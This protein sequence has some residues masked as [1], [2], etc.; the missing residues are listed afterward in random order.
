MG[1]NLGIALGAGVQTG[2]NTYTKMQEEGIAALTKARE[3]GKPAGKAYEEYERLVR[4]RIIV[5]DG[6]AAG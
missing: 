5:V 4:E 6:I 2:L 3:E 1:F